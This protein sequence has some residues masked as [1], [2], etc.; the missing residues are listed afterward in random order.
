LSVLLYGT[1]VWVR[2]IEVS[3]AESGGEETPSG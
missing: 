1:P 2:A 3:S